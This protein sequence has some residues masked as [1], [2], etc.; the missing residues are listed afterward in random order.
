LKFPSSC[1]RLPYFPHPLRKRL[2]AEHRRVLIADDNALYL[3][4]LKRLLL[5]WGMEPVAAFGG[6]DA[7]T[8]SRITRESGLRFSCALLDMDMHDV[9]G[10][11][12]ASSLLSSPTPPAR[13]IL[14]L[15]SPLDSHSSAECKRLGISTILKPIRRAAFSRSAASP[16]KTFTL[17]AGVKPAVDSPQATSLRILLCR[18]QSREPTTDIAHLGKN[19][20]HRCSRQRWRLCSSSAFTAEI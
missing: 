5:K 17:D 16:K 4:L 20:P 9:T 12:L 18:R 7:I 8:T 15:P 3:A 19:R 6:S 11:K 1:L 2:F 13:I 10:L 14:M